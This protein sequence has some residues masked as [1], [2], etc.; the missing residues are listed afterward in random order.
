MSLC[1]SRMVEKLPEGNALLLQLLLC[2]LHHISQHSERNL[3]DAKNLAVCIG[4]SLLLDA[5]QPP[6]LARVEKVRSPGLSFS[7]K[8]FRSPE[9]SESQNHEPSQTKA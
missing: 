7:L 4:P 6:D 1:V 9:A 2:L 8:R 5:S 3:M